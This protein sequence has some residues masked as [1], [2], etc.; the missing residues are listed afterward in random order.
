MNA[1][2]LVIGIYNHPEA[3]PPTLNAVSELS[4]CFNK[5]SIVYRP[6]IKGTW[7]YAGNVEEL[8][9]G[10]FISL[11]DQE[12][13]STTR[14]VLFFLRFVYD[15]FKAC[16]RT[17]PHTVLSYDPIALM[18]Y[19][20]IH[21]F[22]YFKHKIWYHNHDIA[23]IEKLRKFSVGW[24]A[25]KNEPN[26]FKEIDLFTLPSNER[27]RFFPVDKLKGEYIILPNYPSLA[28]YNR[29]YKPK[30]AEN[31]IRLIF[32]GR[33]DQDHG[34]E[35]IIHLLNMPIRCKQL[36]L[37]L[38]GNCSESYKNQ[39]LQIASD[40]AVKDK[41]QFIGFTAYDE[42]PKIAS[43]C[44]IGIAIFAK[45]DVMNNTLGTAS[46]KIYEYAALGL[47]VIY[48]E[49]SGVAEVLKNFEWAIPVALTSMSIKSGIENIMDHY[50]YYSQRAHSSFSEKF[51]FE[52]FFKPVLHYFERNNI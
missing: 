16:D 3:F 44:N 1:K 28:F 18:A 42:V 27:L 38:K 40:N 43:G 39:L 10:A 37:V 52:F 4:H 33:V 31:E 48:L 23:E 35:E 49:Q 15:L 36:Y 8:A 11:N 47:P 21:P 12:K 51:N 46:N 45:K 2:N 30:T 32:Q 50:D 6:N 20:I 19:R 7:K 17:K 13:A 22:L 5:I 14:K 25:C 34:L 9:S 26:F 41:V 24:F 29:F